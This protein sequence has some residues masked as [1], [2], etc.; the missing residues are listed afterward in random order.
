MR[1]CAPG[2]TTLSPFS[3]SLSLTCPLEVVQQGP[4]E[5]ALDGHAPRRRLHRRRHVA[6]VVGQAEGIV[7]DG[8]QGR[9]R[10]TR[11]V[12]PGLGDPHVQAARGRRVRLVHVVQQLA[13]TPGDGVQPEGG[14]SRADGLCV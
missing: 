9:G 10:L 6:L 11:A 4:G 12:A 13:E 8:R 2:V 14:G 7:Q 1:A 5:V 3:L